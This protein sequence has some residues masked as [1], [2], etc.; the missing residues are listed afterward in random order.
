MSD[1]AKRY[2]VKAA[3]FLTVLIL[4][5]TWL[6]QYGAFDVEHR[7]LRGCLEGAQMDLQKVRAAERKMDQFLEE[8]T[9]LD[10]E[11]GRVREIM[12]ESLDADASLQ[13]VR[14]R[15]SRS[16]VEVEENQFRQKTDTRPQEGEMSLLLHGSHP[17]IR[18][19]LERLPRWS[20]IARWKTLETWP[21]GAQ[22]TLTIYAFPPSATEGPETAAP[23]PNP[24]RKPWMQPYAGKTRGQA[25]ELTT[26]ERELAAHQ[27][28][29]RP[30]GGTSGARRSFRTSS[31]SS[32]S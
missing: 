29:C 1:P 16:G 27:K 17:A 31:S 20:R 2:A 23:C 32:T 8:L 13:Y 21:G 5:G 10:Y 11:I 12:P 9:R 15:A 25:E 3:L 22:G 26:L 24:G 6:N 30:S 28:V 4:A 18:D 19:F 7:R 14:T